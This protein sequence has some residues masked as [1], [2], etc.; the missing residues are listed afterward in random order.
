[1]MPAWIWLAAL[2]PAQ[3]PETVFRADLP[4]GGL[5]LST[6]DPGG[7]STR[8]YPLPAERLAGRLVTL[9]V[10]LE[11]EEAGPPPKPWNGIKAM[12]VLEHAGGRE[13]PQVELPAGPFPSR[14]V[15]RTFRAPPGLVR[16]TL[17]LGLEQVAG[18]V[19]FESAEIRT[20][21]PRAAKGGPPF[22]GHS[23]DRL[24]GVMIGPAFVEKDVRDVASWGCNLLRWQLTWGGFPHG[25]ADGAGPEAY[26]AWLAGRLLDLDRAVSLAGELGMQVLVDLHTPPGGRDEAKHCRIFQEKRFQEQFLRVWERIATRYRGNRAVWGYDLVNE[27]F[28]GGVPEGLMGWPDLS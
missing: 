5:R 8:S 22:R 24:R 17:V 18:R 23:L 19:R 13:H 15:Q 10:V 26:D 25:P 6:S 27:P 12:L 20:G 7:S 4:A 21:R 16:A 14:R 9:E 1:M 28:Q 2:L 3:D 11:A